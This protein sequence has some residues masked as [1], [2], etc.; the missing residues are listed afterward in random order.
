MVALHITAQPNASSSYAVIINLK[1]EKY[2]VTDAESRDCRNDVRKSDGE[3]FSFFPCSSFIISNLD[4]GYAETL[5][6]H[7]RMKKEETRNYF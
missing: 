4:L 3:T 7:K 6:L 2:C 1:Q 5:A